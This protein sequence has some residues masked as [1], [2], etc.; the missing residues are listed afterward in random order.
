MLTRL[1][2][3]AASLLVLSLLISGDHSINTMGDRE[4]LPWDT[5]CLAEQAE[6]DPWVSLCEDEIDDC[7]YWKSE[8]NEDPSFDLTEDQEFT[9]DTQYVKEVE[10]SLVLENFSRFYSGYCAFTSR[11]DL[12]HCVVSETGP[13]DSNDVTFLCAAKGSSF[14]TTP[15]RNEVSVDDLSSRGSL[16]DPYWLLCDEQESSSRDEPKCYDTSYSRGKD[17]SWSCEVD[18]RLQKVYRYPDTMEWYVCP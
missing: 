7:P 13:L 8:C 16:G 18:D 15:S 11:A 1:Q 10:C 12:D 9:K 4:C 3:S 5:K 6:C 17:W 2:F 14:L